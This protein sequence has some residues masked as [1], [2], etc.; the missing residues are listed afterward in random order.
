M[1]LFIR[2][3]RYL[4]HFFLNKRFG[5]DFGPADDLEPHLNAMMAYG[6]QHKSLWNY[7]G[8]HCPPWRRPV[9]QHP[10]SGQVS[11]GA[12]LVLFYLLMGIHTFGAAAVEKCTL[13]YS[14]TSCDGFVRFVKATG[15]AAVWPLYWSWTLQ[16]EKPA[17]SPVKKK[18]GAG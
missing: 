3:R 4:R 5:E 12:I 9:W 10:E 18:D 6:T 13:L 14:Q 7:L 17:S 1:S 11:L 15:W 8:M 16:E 2:M